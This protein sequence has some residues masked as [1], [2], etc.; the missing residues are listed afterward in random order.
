M[1]EK[2]LGIDTGTNSLGWA[3]VE[4]YDDGYKLL[5]KG[6]NIFQ[7]GVKIEKGIESS[8][9][10][11]RTS[12]RS[13]RVRYY[14]IKVRKIRL[15]KVLSDNHLCPP[16]T[17]DELS[18]WRLKNIYPNNELLRQWEQT[19]DKADKNPY[20]YRHRCLTEELDLTDLTQ[21][22]I[23]GRALYHIN[24]RRGFLS[25][26][27]SEDGDE[28][29]KVKSGIN[30]LTKDMENMGC[31]YLGE[32]FYRLYQKGEKIRCHYTARNEHYL[33]EFKAICQMQHLDKD[34]VKKL[35]DVIFFQRPLKSQ[36]G[37]VGHC[38]FEPKKPKC[39]I[40][41]PLFEEFRMLSFLNN[42][43]IQT[44]K[45]ES[46]RPL[47]EEERKKILPKFY[48]KSKPTFDFEDIA[49]ELSGKNKYAYYKTPKGKPYLFNYH[50]DTSVSG[51]PVTAGLRDIFGDDW[52]NTIC[53]VYDRAQGKTRLQVIN[54]IWHVLFD[55]SEDEHLMSFGKERLQL[56]DEEAKIF[57][58]IKVSSE[59]A[60]LSLKAICKILP[61]LR[62]GMIYSLS[63]F[64]ANLG[65]VLPSEIWQ[66]EANRHEIEEGILNA[67]SDKD[68]NASDD[69]TTERCIKDYLIANWGV[70]EEECNK[71]YHPSMIES[72]PH[73]PDG[74]NKLGSP[75]IDS[76]RN[77]MAMRSLFRLRHVV[78][79]LLAEGK[80]DRDTTIHIEFARELN[81]ANKRQALA[82]F[83][84][85]NENDR[86]K[87]YAEIVKLYK[88]ETGLTIVP[89]DTDIL[90][91]QLWEEQNHRCIYTDEQIGIVD[92]LGPNPKYDIE[93]TIPRSVGG[94][95]TKMNLTLCNSKFNREVKQ[96]L[97]PS[98]LS[99]HEEILLRVEG[100]K[101]RYEALDKRIRKMRTSSSMSK[102]QKDK[103]IQERNLLKLRRDYWY[104][105][106]QRFVM[107]DVPEGFSR[108]QGTDIS[109]I[110]KYG[111]LYLKS[112][113]N[114]VF[115]V[116]GL[117]TSD[118]RKIWGI[119]DIYTKKER[120]NHVHHCIDAIVIACIGP[121]EYSKLAEY[122]HDEE[123]Y[124]WYGSSKGHI[125]APW[126][127]FQED[128]N[129]IQKEIIVSHNNAD[130]IGKSGKHRKLIKGKKVWVDGDSARAS[131]HNDTYYGA[132]ERD[133]K[134]KYVVRKALDDN[135]KD[136][137]VDNIVDGTVR[138]IVKQA[139][140]HYG[141]LKEA[142]AQGIWMN[143]EKGIAIRKVRCFTP[144]VTR[145]LNIRHQRDVSSKEYKQ[146]FHVMNDTNYAMA[147]YVGQDKKGKERRAFEIV[148]NLD[149]CNFFKESNDKKVVDNHLFPL[150]KND[151]PL[152]YVLKK[153]TMVLLYENTPEEIAECSKEELVKRL[154][155]VTG[156][157]SMVVD[158]RDYGTIVLL[159]SQEARP[160]GEVK[161]KNG[162]YKQNEEFRSSIKLL[163]T[164]FKALIAGRDFEINDL[165]EI[166]W[167]K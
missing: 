80:I 117:A 91:Y 13:A 115:I 36:K 156:I 157:S 40:S 45:D 1:M 114:R 143:K 27:K 100:W 63:V 95:S 12:H 60:S 81:D 147:I 48:R 154:Y 38:V 14:R 4:K 41:H 125:V 151:F 153:G 16:V 138:D 121:G 167:L 124:E 23:L 30:D 90:K 97:L 111:R 158:G 162:A 5:D 132:I 129:K 84:K 86:K 96:T 11:D 105:K 59:Y 35:E 87:A 18:Q 43:K 71:L 26:R 77:P 127:T 93:H 7:E 149:A 62:K 140:Q 155:K 142:I 53:E 103:R 108:R 47:T 21:R 70:A 150:S 102:E 164:Q 32:Y 146:Q 134:V 8:K 29:G 109:V 72:Y 166:K 10:A 54:D 94:D 37:L 85:E 135:F 139:V 141:S 88:E 159:H 137:D 165:G 15:L 55:F 44:P 126:K 19:D 64:F 136:K 128:M 107:T 160:S 99:N 74:V 3:I 52:M 119:Q 104:G 148:S 50:M 67:I 144:S 9:A 130:N 33:S 110:S 122:Y 56:S 65:E 2:I 6:V 17:S 25:N 79:S 49:K 28:E 31:H 22:Y 120:V 133:G 76:I 69:R 152:T 101:E 163:H 123:N 161:A 24:Q 20:T 116:K 98:Q 58:N 68:N 51:C 73:V 34:L 131:L 118:F 66:D 83:V 75:R 42:I 61:Y 112:F 89:T 57:A 92:F 46:L 113:F 106:Y 39:P 145:P 82:T 78:N